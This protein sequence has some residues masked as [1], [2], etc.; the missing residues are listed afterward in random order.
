MD[1]HVCKRWSDETLL[2]FIKEQGLS[3]FVILLENLKGQ[4]QDDFKDAIADANG[5]FGM[6]YPVLLTY[7]SL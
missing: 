6:V 7:G 4:M 3:K 2:P 1:Q 5:L